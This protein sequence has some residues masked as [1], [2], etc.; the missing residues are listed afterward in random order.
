MKVSLNL[1]GG[2]ARGFAHIGVIRLLEEE[3]I[4]FDMIIGISIGA[5]VGGIYAN[6]PNYHHLK[7][8]AIEFVHSKELQNTILGSFAA[9]MDR[10]KNKSLME[11]VSDIYK[12][13]SLVG[14]MLLTKGFLAKEEVDA[15]M[16]HSLPDI[17]IRDTEIPFSCVAVNLYT[18]ERMVFKEGS[19]R[20]SVI[21]SSALPMVLPPRFINKVPYIDGGVLDKVGID[22]GCEAGMDKIIAVDIS[23]EGF[24]KSMIKNSL[25]VLLRAE[26][27]G[28]IYRRR[29]QIT[30]AT[31]LIRPITE[32][33][34]WADYTKYDSLIDAGYEAARKHLDE[35]KD[36]L[37]L[38]SS[39]RR[40][41]PFSYKF[42]P[43]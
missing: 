23:N 43:R 18:G 29:K 31:I 38:T 9:M 11:H 21:A 34:H 22:T 35:I 14:K 16:F 24:R 32:H 5:F 20:D 2:A 15:F 19:L 8:T 6:K 3:K 36:K 28:S 10:T 27:I 30:K 39:F 17:D 40:F 41:F 25:D 1:G 37:K 4:P 26:D 12:K 7:K 33:I 42:S 13:G